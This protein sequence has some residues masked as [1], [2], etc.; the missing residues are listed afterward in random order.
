MMAAGRGGGH[1]E[2]AGVDAALD[3][4]R[5]HAAS[6]VRFMHALAQLARYKL[7]TARGD[8][9]MGAAVCAAVEER[10]S[11]L[12]VGYPAL[13]QRHAL[14]AGAWAGGD[15]EA[16]L[17]CL[18]SEEEA[19]RVRVEASERAMPHIGD[20]E[21]LIEDEWRHHYLERDQSRQE[22]VQLAELRIAGLSTKQH[23]LEGALGRASEVS[24]GTGLDLPEL[25]TG[26]VPAAAETSASASL[27][28]TSCSELVRSVHEMNR[29]TCNAQVR[30]EIMAIAAR[31]AAERQGRAQTLKTALAATSAELR[32]ALHALQAPKSL[33]ARRAKTEGLLGTLQTLQDEIRAV[34]AKRRAAQNLVGDLEDQ[35]APGDPDLQRAQAG[36]ERL[37][38]QAAALGLRRDGVVAEVDALSATPGRDGVDALDALGNE[39]HHLALDFPEVPLRAY[40]IVKPYKEVY[41]SLNAAARMRFDMEVLLRRAGLLA[42]DRNYASYTALAVIGANKANVKRASLRAAAPAAED[43]ILKEYGVEEFKRVKRAVQTASRLRR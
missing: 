27:L 13:K 1:G 19:A 34:N 12:E 26:G 39:Q 29:E 17:T 9:D 23:F 33:H 3:A 35:T 38:D 43:K 25:P 41:E 2:A 32:A 31:T 7:E 30:S 8:E 42:C 20:L 4:V 5:L 37:K 18:A 22:Q 16:L 6:N 11:S 14:L 21:K 10:R 40:R 28:L 15:G 36:L 24:G